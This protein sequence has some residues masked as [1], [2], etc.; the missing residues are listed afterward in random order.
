L[1][2]LLSAE[3]L[4]IA[5]EPRGFHF[6]QAQSAWFSTRDLA[7]AVVSGL[8][9]LR[10]EQ[11]SVIGVSLGGL[12]ATWMAIDARERLDRMVLVSTAASGLAFSARE[13]WKAARPDSVSDA[14]G[15]RLPRG[16]AL[17]FVSAMMRHAPGRALRTV[18][19]PTL[20]IFG[21]MDQVLDPT[22]EQELIEGVPGAHMRTFEAGHDLERKM[23]LELSRL[24]LDFTA[25]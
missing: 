17:G 24:A 8:D 2:E 18:R 21:R 3:A 23:P 20:C 11:V 4:T 6:A 12:V 25:A 5:V 14:E 19:T 1:S 10:V 9:A 7:R 22:A 15:E 13:L 16:S